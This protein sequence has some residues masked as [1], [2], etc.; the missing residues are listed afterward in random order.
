MK[1][2]QTVLFNH[3]T[4]EKGERNMRFLRKFTRYGV[5]IGLGFLLCFL[6]IRGCEREK[7]SEPM[8]VETT[9]PSPAD[10]WSTSKAVKIITRNDLYGFSKGE[11]DVSELIGMTQKELDELSEGLGTPNDPYIRIGVPIIPEQEGRVETLLWNGNPPVTRSLFLLDGRW[12][13][14]NHATNCRQETR[15]VHE[16][17]AWEMGKKAFIRF[18]TRKGDWI[19]VGDYG[20]IP[21]L[22]RTCQWKYG[23]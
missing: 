10:L 14:V 8:E 7:F 20:Q 15:Y 18:D 11:L 1:E 2:L 6:L 22:P 9:P 19:D 12:L 23:D 16:G 3:K 4:T 13:L 5:L 21:D 17:Q